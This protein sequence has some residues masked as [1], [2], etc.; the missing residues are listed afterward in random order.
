M[1]FLR[2]LSDISTKSESPTMDTVESRRSSSNSSRRASRP[3]SLSFSRTSSMASILSELTEHSPEVHTLRIPQIWPVSQRA[4]LGTNLSSHDQSK[5]PT[6]MIHRTSESREELIT[7]QPT[8][9]RTI[10]TS[11]SYTDQ[12][13][14]SKVDPRRLS[15]FEVP[16]GYMLVPITT[17]QTTNSAI[18]ACGCHE[19]PLPEVLNPSYVDESLQ[20][21]LSLS[22]PRKELRIDTTRLLQHPLEEY[23]VTTQDEPSP[24][25]VNHPAEN[26]IFMGRMMN[27]FDKPGYQLGDSLMS[28]YQTV[29]PIVYQYQDEFGEEALR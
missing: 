23:S 17:S 12:A 24:A 1:S 11:K 9:A 7:K 16:E 2:P 3:P 10:S 26:P 22:P 18:C 19:A 8:S 6:E 29:Q 28:G 15:E 21:D 27:Y 25:F 13:K 20:T 5:S 4:S 14:S